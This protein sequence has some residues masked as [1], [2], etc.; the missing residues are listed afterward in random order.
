MVEGKQDQGTGKEVSDR[1]GPVDLG[2]WEELGFSSEY[3]KSFEDFNQGSDM[4]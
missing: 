2:S 3:Q 4:V 1:Q